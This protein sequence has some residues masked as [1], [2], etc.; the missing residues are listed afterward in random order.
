[1]YEWDEL[2][3]VTNLAKHGVDFASMEAFEWEGAIQ[4]LDDSCSEP[5]FVA[6]G[7]IDD[8]LHVVVF[9]ERGDRIRLVSLRRATASERR[10]YAET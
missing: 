1:M 9:T 5:R 7:Y 4:R 10:R 6:V 3:R 8:R 2:K